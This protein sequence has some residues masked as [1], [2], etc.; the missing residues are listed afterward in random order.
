MTQGYGA[1]E[2]PNVQLIFL[3]KGTPVRILYIDTVCG[4]Y[5]D[6]DN[7]ENYVK[8][9]WALINPEDY[10]FI[11]AHQYTEVLLYRA[12][13]I[14]SSETGDDELYFPPTLHF[15][16]VE[17]EYRLEPTGDPARWTLTL[18]G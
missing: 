1:R 3:D 6:I 8:I 16:K 4:Y 15:H 13:I 9:A 14:R 2:A 5:E 18:R 11:V 12:M 17:F 10:D 7:E